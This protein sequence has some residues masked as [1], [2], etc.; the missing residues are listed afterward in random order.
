MITYSVKEENLFNDSVGFYKSF[1]IIAVRNEECIAYIPDVF[2]S[3]DDATNFVNLCNRSKFEFIHL[4][5][6]VEDTVSMLY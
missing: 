5:D 1:G 4:Q 3:K 2:L 6:I